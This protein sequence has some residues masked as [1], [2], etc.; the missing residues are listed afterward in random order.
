MNSIQP[1]NLL[2]K[3]EGTSRL[4]HEGDIYDSQSTAEIRTVGQEQFV[5][6]AYAWEI[7][8]EA[9]DGRITYLSKMKDQPTKA[10]WLDSW[11][12]RDSIMFCEATENQEGTVLLNGSY[13]APAGLDWG[14]RIEVGSD[15][16]GLLLIRMFN[17]SPTGQEELAVQAEYRKTGNLA[18]SS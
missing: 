12:M 17:I 10:T 18:L 13:P 14:W 4:F 16:G 5:S 6:I 11:H 1:V 7:E 15:R 8:G 2:G 3:W 9:Q